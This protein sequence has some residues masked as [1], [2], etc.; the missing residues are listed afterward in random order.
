MTVGSTTTW[1]P[2]PVVAVPALALLLLLLLPPL[3]C[4][5]DTPNMAAAKIKLLETILPKIPGEET[6]QNLVVLIDS[7]GRSVKTLKKCQWLEEKTDDNTVNVN[8][9]LG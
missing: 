3:F 8:L 2:F 9:L 5:W 1:A 4:A 7:H 6:E